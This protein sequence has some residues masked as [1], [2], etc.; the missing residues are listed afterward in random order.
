MVLSD[1]LLTL[2]NYL[3][4]FFSEKMRVFGDNFAYFSI[5]T[6]CGYSLESPHHMLWVLIRIAH[7]GNSNEYP[8]S[9]SV[10]LNSEIGKAGI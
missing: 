7:R 4:Y 6:C 3:H 10:L 1:N 2:L 8:Q 5:K 9:G